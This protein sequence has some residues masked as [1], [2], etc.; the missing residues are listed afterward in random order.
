MLPIFWLILP[1]LPVFGAFWPYIQLKA[2]PKYRRNR[3]LGIS[4]QIEISELQMILLQIEIRTEIRNFR[5]LV[6]FTPEQNWINFDR[7]CSRKK[8]T[9]KKRFQTVIYSVKIFLHFEMKQNLETC[10]YIDLSRYFEMVKC[11]RTLTARSFLTRRL[12]FAS[13]SDAWIPLE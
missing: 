1:I 11:E 5:G 9:E 10:F 7:F 3:N 8:L 6:D 4:L 13:L 2:E 12:G